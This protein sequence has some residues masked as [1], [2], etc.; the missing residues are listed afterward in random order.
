[1]TTDDC[2]PGYTCGKHPVGDR[3]QRYEVRCMD[4][5]GNVEIVGWADDPS[6]LI[7]SVK[8]HPSYHSPF[9]FDRGPSERGSRRRVTWQWFS[10]PRLSMA[11][12]FVF[13]TAA[14]L[15]AGLGDHGAA[16]AA[17]LQAIGWLG[18]R[19]SYVGLGRGD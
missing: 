8:S 5:N 15:F 12:A 3:R 6:G 4:L 16:I 10:L 1:M 18:V 14:S 2:D 17:A 9:L 13:L 7:A 19:F 11:A